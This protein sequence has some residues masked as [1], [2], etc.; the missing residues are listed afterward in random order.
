MASAAPGWAVSGHGKGPPLGTRDEAPALA[1]P[2]S[3]RVTRGWPFAVKRDLCLECSV[4]CQ[5]GAGGQPSPPLP[6][7]ALLLPCPYLTQ[8][9]LF[10]GRKLHLRGP[11]EA[12]LRRLTL[13]F[14]F[15]ELLRPPPSTHL[16]SIHPPHSPGCR[17][18]CSSA[19]STVPDPHKHWTSLTSALRVLVFLLWPQSPQLYKASSGASGQSVELAAG[20]TISGRI[21]TSGC[22]R[23]PRHRGAGF[24]GLL[25]P[26]EHSN[27][28]ILGG[29]SGGPDLQPRRINLNFPWGRWLPALAT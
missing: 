8:P 28:V 3:Y 25:E 4:I 24:L 10:P 20:S 9:P 23:E 14:P 27:Q 12:R 29:P 13:G 19:L 11:L 15:F 6:L 21:V 1:L 2:L 5:A 26:S 17:L 18:R 7:P 22:V 16:F